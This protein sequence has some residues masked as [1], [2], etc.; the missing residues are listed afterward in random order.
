MDALLLSSFRAGGPGFGG[1][2]DLTILAFTGSLTL[3]HLA[4]ARARHRQWLQRFRLR[5]HDI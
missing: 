2:N 5:C 3:T 1:S 4:H